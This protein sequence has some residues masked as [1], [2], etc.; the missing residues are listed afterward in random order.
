M[1]TRIFYF[2]TTGNSYA[3]AREIAGSIGEARLIPIATAVPT[4]AD[5][6][7]VGFV[8]PV[9]GWGLPR[10]VADFIKR[11]HFTEKPYVFGVA[12]CGGTPARTLVEL[13]KLLRKAGADLHAGFACKDGAN[14][15]TDEP[16]IVKFAK[17][18]NRR[19]CPSAE[20]RLPQIISVIR[21]ERKHAPETSSLA[22]NMFGRLMHSMMLLAGDKLKSADSNYS[23]DER[24]KACRTCERICPRGNVRIEGGRPVW[25]HNCEMC[26]GCIQW[27]PQ[28][29]IHL[30]NDTRR[31]HN[32]SV[33]AADLM[34][35]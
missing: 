16:G 28:Q 8:F 22:A 7:K 18:L 35:R 12:T 19:Q 34:L 24:C 26:Y 3:M 11:L 15:V 13:R 20:E 5:A 33:K 10:I 27:C 23:V 1:E 14:T 9:Y 6:Q 25:H 17:K 31:Y 4:D 32:P 29:A 21:D 30:P 2:S